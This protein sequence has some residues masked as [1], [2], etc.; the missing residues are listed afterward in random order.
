MYKFFGKSDG[1]IGR[2]FVGTGRVA[3]AIGTAFFV[4]IGVNAG[5]EG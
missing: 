1:R 2:F 4:A 5:N 3:V